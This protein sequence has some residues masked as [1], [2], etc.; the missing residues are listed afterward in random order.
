M[1]GSRLRLFYLSSSWF[2]VMGCTTSAPDVSSPRSYGRVLVADHRFQ[3]LLLL[4][5]E[6]FLEIAFLSGARPALPMGV[7]PEA[8][9]KKNSGIGSKY[10]CC[11]Q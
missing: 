9:A 3:F 5:V 2:I 8:I 6:F 10:S 4:F 7:A 11:H 1:K